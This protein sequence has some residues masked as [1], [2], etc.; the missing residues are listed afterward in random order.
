MNTPSTSDIRTSACHM[1]SKQHFLQRSA[2]SVAIAIAIAVAG[3]TAHATTSPSLPDTSP[4]M[5]E[6]SEVQAPA[7]FATLVAQVKPAVV[8]IAVTGKSHSAS[9]A[10]IP[11]LELPDDPYFQDF[12]ERFFRQSP[13]QSEQHVPTPRVQGVGSGFIVTADGYIVTS[14]HVIEDATKIEVVLN[15]GER[16]PAVVQGRDPKTDLALLKVTPERELPYVVF[17]DSAA[18]RP[19][20]WVVAIGNPFGLGGTATSGI[21]SAR[22]RDIQNG[23]YDD[24]LQIDAPINRGNSGG[25]LFDTTGSVIG[26]NTAIYSPTGGNVG[27]GFAVPAS[28]AKVVIEQLMANGHVER[29][30]LGVQIQTITETLAESMRLP[31][32][33]G[34]LVA[35]VTPDS[36]AARAG[37][38]VGD[39][40][41][42]FDGHEVSTMKD[43]PK[44][45]AKTVPGKETGLILWRQG[46]EMDLAVTIARTADKT[47]DAADVAADTT[48]SAR[49]GMSLAPLTDKLRQRYAVPSVVEGAVVVEVESGSPA[50]E[51]GIRAGDVIVQAGDQPVENPDDLVTVVRKSKIA[52]SDR[53]LLLVNRQGN[54]RFVSVQAG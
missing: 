33:N 24:Y 42:S 34:A 50:A 35:D 47:A 46:D 51:E 30:W 21:I 36:P 41:L 29:G 7:S 44:L 3:M 22:G 38:R 17:G 54:Q 32:I 45:V 11:D 10:G 18:T 2:M 37:I 14:N 12:F 23:P 1:R 13:P 43:L 49:L 53:V 5:I 15:N 16:L 40:I 6:Q 9:T 20:D 48:G 39:V 4:L 19:G 27:I 31:D 25:P 26:V 52:G 28:Q 8:N